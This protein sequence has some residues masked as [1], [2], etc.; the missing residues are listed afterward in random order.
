MSV[1]NFGSIY[2]AANSGRTMQAGT[3][4][5]FTAIFVC[6]YHTPNPTPPSW[7]DCGLLN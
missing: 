4:T 7:Q 1:Q 3:A 5:G 6:I 2:L